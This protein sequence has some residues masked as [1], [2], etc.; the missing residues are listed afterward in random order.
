MGAPTE[1]TSSARR[2]GAGGGAPTPPP[3]TPLVEC[4]RTAPAWMHVPLTARGYRTNH[5]PWDAAW[6]LLGVHG[7][8]VN[9][10]SHLLGLGYFVAMTPHVFGVLVR[11]GAPAHDYALFAAFLA[12]AGVQMGAS[13]VYHAFRCV[14]AAA[15]ASLLLLDIYGILAMILGSWVVGM[16]Q[17]F[18]CHPALGAAYV[19]AEVALLALVHWFGSRAVARPSFYVGYYAAVSAAIAWGLVPCVHISL[20]CAWDGCTDVLLNAQLGMFGNYALGFAVFLARVPERLVP[21]AFDIL[22]HSH[23]I[24]HAFVFLAG[25][26]WLLGMLEFNTL[27]LAHRATCALE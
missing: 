22:G 7:D 24:W 12:G 11:N 3:S 21:D 13:T 5:A 18:E 17:G 15:E 16:G 9:I 14:S 20:A 19:G 10:W 25:R 2:R 1:S 23:Q 8:T 6:S 26:A 4:T 27:K